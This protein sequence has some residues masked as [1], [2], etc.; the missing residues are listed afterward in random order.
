[1][2]PSASA[3]AQTMA[4]A[5]RGH[6]LAWGS[7]VVSAVVLALF[8]FMVVTEMLGYGQTNDATRRLLEYLPIAT[9]SYWLGSNAGSASKE[10]M[11]RA[12][13]QEQG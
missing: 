9:G 6:V 4:L 5:E 7:A 2:S 8:A 3:R 13:R 1:M 10:R 11:L 12:S